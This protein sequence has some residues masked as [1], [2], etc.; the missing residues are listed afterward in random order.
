M[1]SDFALM[2]GGTDALIIAIRLLALVAFP[3]GA[4]LA[5]WN[6][7]QVLRSRRR[8]LAKI[9]SVV[10]ALACLVVLWVGIVCH[11]MGFSANY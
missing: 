3:I 4:L 7:W 2:G 6:A 9:W 10:L 8:L 5:L 11:V 1:M